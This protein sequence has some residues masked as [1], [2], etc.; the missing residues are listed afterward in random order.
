V[1]SKN[2][3]QKTWELVQASVPVAC[4]DVLPLRR[5]SRESA[6]LGLILRATPDAGNSWCLIGGR[7][8]RDS[9]VVAGAIAELADAL[10]DGIAYEP[11]TLDDA[12]VV[13]YLR[14]VS[15]SAPYDPRQ[16]SIATTFPVWCRG[17]IEVSGTEALD[18][19][20]F[21]LEEIASLKIGFGQE[22]VIDRLLRRIGLSG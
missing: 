3:P 18:F 12:I 15:A 8:P 9:G 20:W 21:D 10:G 16:H 11:F 4:V 19:R 17:E 13:E 22:H 1:N 5:A 2:L 7:M 14:G 6:Q